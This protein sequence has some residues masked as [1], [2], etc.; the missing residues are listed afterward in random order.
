MNTYY[1]LLRFRPNANR[2]EVEERKEAV[3]ARSKSEALVLAGHRLALAQAEA[4]RAG[5]PPGG[6][7]AGSLTATCERLPREPAWWA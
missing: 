4:R 1:V 7:V 2:A 6:I 5:G 3:R